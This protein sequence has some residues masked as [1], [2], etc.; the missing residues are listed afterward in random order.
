MAPIR[1]IE[2]HTLNT[3]FRPC[4]AWKLEKVSVIIFKNISINYL[5]IS[6]GYGVSTVTL[7]NGMGL[8]FILRSD[9]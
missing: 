4:M 5:N 7:L 1:I 2:N 8:L 3:N 9:S 6:G